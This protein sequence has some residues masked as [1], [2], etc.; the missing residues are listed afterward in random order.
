[1]EG[2]SPEGRM[3]PSENP[4][5]DADANVHRTSK[6]K[7]KP[8]IY[9][10]ETRGRKSER[11]YQL[12][13]T[14]AEAKAVVAKLRNE[15]QQLMSDCENV[16]RVREKLNEMDISMRL[17]K[18]AHDKYHA[19][20]MDEYDIEESKEYYEYEEIKVAQLVG[21]MAKW[22]N[23]ESHRIEAT[24]AEYMSDSIQPE[25]SISNVGAQ[26]RASTK[27]R[28]KTSTTAV[29]RS[30]SSQTSTSRAAKSKEAAKAVET[31]TPKVYPPE[32]KEKRS[33]LGQD[34]ELYP[35]SQQPKE[36]SKL[37]KELSEDQKRESSKVSVNCKQ[38]S[39]DG[40]KRVYSDDD[41]TLKSGPKD[42]ITQRR[43]SKSLPVELTKEELK[44]N[45]T[46]AKY[47]RKKR[48]YFTK[49]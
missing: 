38:P 8:K 45:E 42:S 10:Y 18:D 2:I 46:F 37:R 27:N 15:L 39:K 48:N 5:S 31:K 49:R 3:D 47:S 36:R 23:E 17:L 16:D 33:E 26:G 30:K 13:R 32:S 11:K 19:E 6:P 9:E 21:R 1:M 12:K 44:T 25:D 35:A 29:N 7:P 14:R 41:G 40:D 24:I 22:I 43:V 4:K 28:K 34:K 20:L